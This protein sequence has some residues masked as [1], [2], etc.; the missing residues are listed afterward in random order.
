M[1]SHLDLM[2]IRHPRLLTISLLVTFAGVIVFATAG[3]GGPFREAEPLADH[4]IIDMHCHTAGIGAGGSGCFVSA[5]MQNSYKFDLYLHSFGTSRAEVIQRG[6]AIVIDRLA[7]RLQKSRHVGRAVVLALDGAVDANGDL[8]RS[9]TEIYVPNEFVAAEVAKHSNLLFGA[10]VNP[11]RK[12]ALQRLEWAKA[13]G[14]VLVKWLPSI[15]H[16]NPADPALTPFY[17][18]LVELHLPLLT[19]T[20]SEHSFTLAEDQLCDPERL[21]LPLQRGVT[22]IAA[23]AATTGTYEGERSIDRLARLMAEFPNC[24]ADISSLTQINKHNDLGAVLSRPEFSGRLL[25]GTDYPLVAM[26]VL[27]SPQYYVGRLSWRQRYAIGRVENVW[28]RDVALKQALGMPTDVWTR[29]ERVLPLA[30]AK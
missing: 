30:R 1:R 16:I 23:H 24:Y 27:V 7:E 12:D 14:A 9:R 2:K 19:H 22:I 11:Y 25:Y 10:S 20:G 21:R 15:Q 6:D 4:K 26:N 13:H 18:K 8:D 28:D 3:L 17:D 5:A 29:A